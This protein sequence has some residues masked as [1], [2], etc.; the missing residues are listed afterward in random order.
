MDKRKI[1][2]IVQLVI[3][4]TVWIVNILLSARGYIY[5][6]LAISL[7]FCFIQLILHQIVYDKWKPVLIFTVCLSALGLTVDSILSFFT[8][9]HFAA[10]PFNNMIASPFLVGIWVSFSIMFYSLLKSWFNRYGLISLLSLVGFPLAYYLG[11]NLGAAESHMGIS[12]YLLV[13]I[14]WSIFLPLF[15][16]LN[17]IVS[18]YVQ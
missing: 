10:N 8:I 1:N 11:A 17:N 7:P 12:A 5:I 14:I 6:G 9:I 2:I 3:Y 18:K 4:N 13:G 16:Y 15:L